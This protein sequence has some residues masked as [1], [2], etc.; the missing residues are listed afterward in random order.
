MP[1]R[2]RRW[3][4]CD[5][6]HRAGPQQEASQRS[7]ASV[8]HGAS[9]IDRAPKAFAIRDTAS[10]A[11]PGRSQ[12]F[13]I[14]HSAS[15]AVGAIA[16][17]VGRPMSSI[18][19]SRRR[20]GARTRA[21]LVRVTGASLTT[22]REGFMLAIL[23]EFVRTAMPS[24]DSEYTGEAVADLTSTNGYETNKG[25]RDRSFYGSRADQNRR[26]LVE[27]GIPRAEAER[28]CEGMTSDPEP[29]IGSLS[30]STQ[31]AWPMIATRHP[32]NGFC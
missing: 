27:R 8:C 6:A 25:R 30:I 22:N 29:S 14:A 1:P 32:G 16:F 5:L 31:R 10:Y 17:G 4:C 19:G 12:R 23:D 24:A 2:E 18:R 13:W 9:S 21:V 7:R 20:A 26:F 11:L 15:G 28:M 3:A